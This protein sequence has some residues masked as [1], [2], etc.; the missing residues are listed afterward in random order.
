VRTSNPA[1]STELTPALDPHAVSIGYLLPTRDAITLARPTTAPLL[2]LG[3][4]AEELGFDAIWVGDGPLARARHDTLMMLAALAARTERIALGSGVLLAAL[5]PALLLAQACS[6]LDQIAEGRL[7]LGLG[8]GFPF[9]ETELQFQAVGVPYAGR[10][11]RLTETIAA[12]RTLWQHAGTPISFSGRHIQLQDVALEPPPYRPGGPP[13]W[14]AGFGETAERRVGELADGWLPYPPSAEQYA[15]GWTRV[16]A[17]AKAAGRATPP[18]PGLYATVAIDDTA[19]VAHERLQR[20]TQRY[21]NQPLEIMQM[22]QATFAGTPEEVHGWLEQYI[23]AGARHIVLRVSDE[24]AERGLEAA[25]H[26]LE[27]IRAQHLTTRHRMGG[28]ETSGTRGGARRARGAAG[29]QP[30]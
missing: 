30:T 4:R 18:L 5:R 9:P 20:N 26:T 1:P 8:A 10:V 17:A 27:L 22:I 23:R 13:V 24:Q 29:A 19:Q 6:T 7:V 14:L 12:L 2:A 28:N 16:S 11:Q 21:Y 3:Q 25:A 15:E